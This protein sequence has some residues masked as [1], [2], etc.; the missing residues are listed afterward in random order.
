MG[1]MHA[2]TKVLIGEMAVGGAAL[3][4]LGALR[5][6][7]VLPYPW[8]VLLHVVGAVMLVG[9]IAVSGAWMTMAVASGKAD[10]AAFGARAVNW[11]DA[12]MTVPGIL[13]LTWNG[14]TIAMP[15]GGPLAER[16]V[17]AASALF[18]VSGLLYLTALVPDQERMIRRSSGAAAG[19]RPRPEFVRAFRRWAALGSL[20]SVFALASLALMELRPEL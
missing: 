14:L 4:V 8:H 16:W 2:S 13:L 10:I 15:S 19:E 20:S 1:G 17:V 18:G 5:Y 9:N 11:M 7:L 6:P 3:G 12:A